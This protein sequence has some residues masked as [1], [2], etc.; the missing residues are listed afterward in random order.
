LSSRTERIVDRCPRFYRGWDVDSTVAKLVY[1]VSSE[2]DKAEDTVTDLIG[3][4]WVDTAT[5]TDIDRIGIMFGIKRRPQESD[6]QY[7]SYLKH[8]VDQ[9]R[10]GGTLGGILSDLEMALGPESVAIIENPLVESHAEFLVIANDTWKLGSQSIQNEA[11]ALTLSVEGKGAVSKPKITNIETGESITF[12][13]HLSLG[14]KLI[15]KGGQAFIGEKEVSQMVTSADGLLPRKISTWKY[16]EALLEGIGVFDKGKFNENTFAIGVP[17][18]KIQF[19]WVRRQPA[20]FL[21]KVKPY[22]LQKSQLT[23]YNIERRLE[24]LRAAGVKVIVKVTEE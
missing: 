6:E 16:S 14:E 3:S 13:G 17:T 5:G 1:S 18:V 9:Y 7:R 4:H 24:Y 11:F 2:L 12:N 23:Q 8:S 21:V 20:T 22:A 10:G 15:L 19:D